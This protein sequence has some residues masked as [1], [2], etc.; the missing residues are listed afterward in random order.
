MN[1]AIDPSLMQVAEASGST[2]PAD[3]GAYWM[4]FTS[5]RQ[6]KKAPRLL[7]WCSSGKCRICI[8]W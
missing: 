7:A 6:F 5:N 4:P 8:T 2:L 1:K 3:M